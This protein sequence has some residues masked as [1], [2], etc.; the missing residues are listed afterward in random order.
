MSSQKDHLQAEGHKIY[1][2]CVLL[3][4]LRKS[5]LTPNQ[6]IPFMLERQHVGLINNLLIS[7][8][9]K[10]GFSTESKH[11]YVTYIFLEPTIIVHKVIR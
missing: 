1:K 5:Q 7:Y 8:L 3:K 6:N 10:C 4:C 9:C 2:M 11:I